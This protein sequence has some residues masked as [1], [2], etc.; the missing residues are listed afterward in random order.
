VIAAS[1]LAFAAPAAA[2]EV[3]TVVVSFADLILASPAG[4]ETLDGRIASAVT[5]VCGK[6]APGSAQSF[7]TVKDCRSDA[8]A[9]AMEQLEAKIAS[10]PP[11]AVAAR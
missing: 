5:L 8:M 1:V 3:V 11:V 7:K 2:G 6:P 4:R 10:L 9:D